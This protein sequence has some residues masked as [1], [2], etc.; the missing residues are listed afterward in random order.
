[1]SK[2]PLAK[3][4]RAPFLRAMATR[5]MTRLRSRMREAASAFCCSSKF[6]SVVR[7]SAVASGSRIR[8][9]GGIRNRLRRETVGE[10]V[11]DDERDDLAVVAHAR[12]D[13]V[14]AQVGAVDAARHAGESP[15]VARPEQLARAEVCARAFAEERGDGRVAFGREAAQ[16]GEDAERAEVAGVADVRVRGL[17][18]DEEGDEARL[19]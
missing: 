3:T 7:R 1:M 15:A 2:Q 18:A 11:A 8:A 4:T 12:A 5:A 16:D 9:R 14:G 6:I 19:G 13:A 10:V 17:G